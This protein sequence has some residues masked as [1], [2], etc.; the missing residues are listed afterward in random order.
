MYYSILLSIIS[1]IGV[2]NAANCWS[3]ALGYDCCDDCNSVYTDGSGD[4]G[5]KNNKWCGVPTSCA[6]NTTTGSCWSKALGYDCCDNCN[7]VYTDESGDW[8]IKNKDWCGIP[9]TCKTNANNNTKS[10]SNTN[11]NND[12]TESETKPVI[13]QEPIHPSG[14]H[15]TLEDILNLSEKKDELTW[16]DFEEYEYEDIGSGL[17]IWEFKVKE[18]SEGYSLWVGGVPP[19]KPY[20]IKLFHGINESTY[21]G[22]KGIDTKNGIDIR[23]DDV[24]GF[25]HES[26]ESFFASSVIGNKLSLGKDVPLDGIKNIEVSNSMYNNGTPELL[27]YDQIKQIITII[28]KIK[29]LKQDDLARDLEGNYNAI[30]IVAHNGYTVEIGEI[31]TYLIIDNISYM[32]EYEACQELDVFVGTVLNEPSEPINVNIESDSVW[33]WHE[34][35]YNNPNIKESI[36]VSTYPDIIFN[37]NGIDDDITLEKNGTPLTSIKGAP[38]IN[39]FFTDLNH[40]GYPEICT[41]IAFGSGIVDLHVV[42]YDI[43]HDKELQDQ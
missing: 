19:T 25:T 20:Y 30:K 24:W 37:W 26:L 23:Y 4:W 32:A 15:I 5:V 31:G 41:T 28:K 12:T 11:Y 38:I 29:L 7:S 17:Y 9:K 3:K 43:H 33:C 13:A 22:V 42:V 6:L 1:L 8:G 40:D 27:T 21:P 36:I 16:S 2:T 39:A 34:Q 10:T 18:G 35:I 14:K